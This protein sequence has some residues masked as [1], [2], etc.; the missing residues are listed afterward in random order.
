MAKTK[1]ET[2]PAERVDWVDTLKA[3]DER[4]AKRFVAA[5]ERWMAAHRITWEL[6][7][8]T[9]NASL[10]GVRNWGHRQSAKGEYSMPSLGQLYKLEQ[11][12]GGL[13]REIFPVEGL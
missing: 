8:G 9:T 6:V 12:K 7:S 1:A 13:I 10:N 3:A 5:M 11:L 4:L 2:T